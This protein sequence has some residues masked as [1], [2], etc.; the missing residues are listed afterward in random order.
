[1]I[2]NND[3][4]N[5]E[6]RKSEEGKNCLVK[7]CLLSLISKM[8]KTFLNSKLELPELCII[9]SCS[10]PIELKLLDCSF[11]DVAVVLFW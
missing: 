4:G 5:S 2:I 1:M 11:D 6:G 9:H 7:I 8:S 3:E 10:I